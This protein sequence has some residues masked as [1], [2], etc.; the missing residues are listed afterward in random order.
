MKEPIQYWAILLQDKQQQYRI[1]A[2]FYTR[3]EA[4]D[5][6][7]IIKSKGYLQE[8]WYDFICTEV[9]HNHS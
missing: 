2:P 4:Q 7:D 3:E 9:P 1:I 5:Y 8:Y 6:A